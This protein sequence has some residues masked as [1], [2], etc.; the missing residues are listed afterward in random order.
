MGFPD[1]GL[2]DPCHALEVLGWPGLAIAPDLR[3]KTHGLLH[4][5]ERH[6]AESYAHSCRVARLAM[7]MWRAAPDQLGCGATALL[8][9]V[10]HDIGKLSVPEGVLA[11]GRPL[12]ARER[13]AVTA[14]A[15]DGA[16]ILSALGFPAGVVEIAAHHHERWGAGGYPT[17]QAAAEFAPITR[18]VAVADA[19]T[20]MTEPGRAYRRPLSPEAARLELERCRGTHF[21]PEAV[22]ILG[23]CAVDALSGSPATVARMLERLRDA[24]CPEFVL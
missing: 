17:G 8:G 9:S 14:H 10:L 5:L 1:L 20:A 18:A 11:S 16:A 23:R 6:H 22:A 3:R 24:A 4:R 13:L 2:P 15:A 21:D 7:A 19:F 12:S